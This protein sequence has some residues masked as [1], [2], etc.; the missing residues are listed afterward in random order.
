MAQV[1]AYLAWLFGPGEAQEF[2]HLRKVTSGN[3]R[4]EGAGGLSP[5]FQPWEPTT[6]AARP[7]AEGAPDRTP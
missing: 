2:G 5:G 6:R 4:P 3:L 7:G 1:E